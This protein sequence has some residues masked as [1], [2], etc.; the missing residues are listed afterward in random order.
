MR[1]SSRSQQVNTSRRPPEKE[2]K[3]HELGRSEPSTSYSSLIPLPFFFRKPVC[4]LLSPI[5]YE[6]LSDSEKRAIYDRYGEEGLKQQ[7][8]Q[9]QGFHDPFDMFAQFFGGGHRHQ[10][11]EQERRGPEM[12]LELEVTLEELYSGKSIEI[13]VSKQIVCPHC[14]GSGARSSEDVVTC[15]TCQGQGVRIVKHM[16]APGMFQQFRQT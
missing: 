10:H 6:V 5:A 1:G 4:P 2:R 7:Q 3:E 11:A 14:S 8:G 16:L 9:G 12:R 15:S 13:E